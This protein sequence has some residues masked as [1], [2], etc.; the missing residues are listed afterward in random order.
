MEKTYVQCAKYIR[1]I[2]P[3]YLMVNH[4]L[5]IVKLG[6][7]YALQMSI[8]CYLYPVMMRIYHS[9]CLGCPPPT[10]CHR[11]PQAAAGCWCPLQSGCRSRGGLLVTHPAH[12]TSWLPG[13]GKSPGSSAN[14]VLSQ[15][16]RSGLAH[17]IKL[18][19]VKSPVDYEVLVIV[20]F[21][22]FLWAMHCEYSDHKFKDFCI[23][24]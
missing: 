1:S 18:S 11:L 5:C 10:G 2:N 20:F 12:V 21:V 13:S 9:F 17:H 4:Q 19:S 15:R 16:A 6:V 24:L 22:S 14:A 7:V 3:L 23:S 8:P